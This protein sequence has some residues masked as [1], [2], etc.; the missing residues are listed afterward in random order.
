MCEHAVVAP[1]EY[2][3]KRALSNA[4]IVLFLGF[5]I[6][7][8]LRYYLGKGGYDERF[9][10]R[11]FSTVRLQECSIVVTEMREGG[12]K[13]RVAVGRDLQVGW[14]N[15]L[16]R[17]RPEVIAKYLARRCA[18]ENVS[19]VELVGTCHDAGDHDLPE[20]HYTRLCGEPPMH[21]A[22]AR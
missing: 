20:R 5:Q 19:Q 11:M 3:A 2:V 22:N 12:S 17:L 4:F 18:A 14:V 13:R 7:V 6:A 8:P 16:E 15:L 9:S 21:Q 1:S 10:W